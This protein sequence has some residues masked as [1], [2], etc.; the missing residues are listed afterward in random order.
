VRTNVNQSI[1]E[2][3]RLFEERDT[4]PNYVLAASGGPDSQCLLKA[5]THIV[6]PSRC[7][8]VCVDHGLR[9][10]DQLSSEHDLVYKT[11]SD[12]GCDC[13]IF[14]VSITENSPSIQAEARNARYG[15][16]KQACDQFGTN[17]IVTGH[18]Y[19]DQ[20]ETVLIKLLR[21]TRPNI[22]NV[23]TIMEKPDCVILRPLLDV[24]RDSILGYL[25]RWDVPY[26]T[27]PSN[28]CTD[29]YLRNWVR[30][31]LLPKMEEKSPQI[32]K[33]LLRL[34]DPEV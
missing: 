21:G 26:I 23:I 4:P 31:E 12:I 17:I 22:M 29:K 14:K 1:K 32:R 15:A 10:H 34:S 16:L 6:D 19:D 11:A 18:N 3:I 5:F 7:L 27:D 20:V 24:P 9:S 2:N 25:K 28:L 13:K 30:H 33:F 8:V